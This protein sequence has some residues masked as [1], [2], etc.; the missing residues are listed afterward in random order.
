M[1]HLRTLIAA[2][3][4]LVLCA[5]AGPAASAPPNGTLTLTLTAGPVCP[6][7][8]NPPNPACAPRA[9]SGA[10]VAIFDGDREVTRGASN[11]DGRID[12]SL[13]FG[14]Y[15]VRPIS[16]GGFPTPP[17]DQLVDIGALP[18]ELALAYDTGIR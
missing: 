16:N 8:Q 15:T 12:F 10:Q 11:A 1:T 6:V 4:L 18:V 7:E 9:V 3:L 5:C 14:R 13:P 17:G 2:A